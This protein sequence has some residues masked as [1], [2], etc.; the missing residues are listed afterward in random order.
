MDK[1]PITKNGEKKLRKELDNLTNVERPKIIEAISVAREH[2]DLK[3]NAEYHAARE[4]QSFVEGR[5]KDIKLKLSNAE[6]VD[7]QKI[8]SNKVV[9]SAKVELYDFEKESE[10]IYSIVG[11]D[12]ADIKEGLI[13]INSPI[14][15]SLIG[16][17]KGDVVTVGTPSGEKEFEI[18]EIFYG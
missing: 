11:D 14:A 1:F 12:E 8:T 17:E 5:I 15:R 4:Q 18:L 2:G 10:L 13:S 3:E 16:K 9:F 6:I 7:P